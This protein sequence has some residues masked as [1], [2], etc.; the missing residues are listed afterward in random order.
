VLGHTR[1]EAP[2]A[3]RKQFER[4]LG[5]RRL[6]LGHT[7]VYGQAL[8]QKWR[9]GGTRAGCCVL[10]ISCENGEPRDNSPRPPRWRQPRAP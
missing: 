7:A 1:D 4:F 3:G 9:G 8:H 10:A 5:R 6:D 2:V